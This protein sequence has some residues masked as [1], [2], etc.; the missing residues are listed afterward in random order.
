VLNVKPVR[1]IGIALRFGF[2]SGRMKNKVSDEIVPYPVEVAE[3]DDAQQKFVEKRW[4]DEKQDFVPVKEGEMPA[5]I[6]KYRRDSWYDSGERTTWSLPLDIK[7]S[8]FMFDGK[9]RVRTEFYLGAENVLSLFY[10]AEGNTSFNQY[11]GQMDTG[12]NSAVY[13]LPIPMISFGF[14]WTY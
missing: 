7:V 2:A 13:E 1:Q 5:I 6:Q 10:G 4:D 12:A 8:F 3:W 11:T 9:G 14:K